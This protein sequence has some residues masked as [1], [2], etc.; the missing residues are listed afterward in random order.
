MLHLSSPRGHALELLLKK[1]ITHLS[2]GIR[3]QISPWRRYRFF[4][5]SSS[6]NELLHLIPPLVYLRA[7]RYSVIVFFYVFKKFIHPYLFIAR[8]TGLTTPTIRKQISPCERYRFNFDVI[9]HFEFLSARAPPSPPPPLSPCTL[10]LTLI[11]ASRLTHLP[12][13]F[14]LFSSR[15]SSSSPPFPT[16][17]HFPGWLFFLWL[18]FVFVYPTKRE[19]RGGG[20]R[21][22][23]IAVGE[24]FGAVFLYPSLLFSPSS[25]FPLITLFLSVLRI[26]FDLL[27][28]HLRRLRISDKNSVEER[29]PFGEQMMIYPFRV[30]Y[31]C[32]VRL[33][34]LLFWPLS[35]TVSRQLM[36][37]A[38]F[39]LIK[40]NIYFLVNTDPKNRKVI[41]KT[42]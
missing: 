42:H 2:L 32:R 41:L 30:D 40:Y 39:I 26:S 23:L 7:H 36:I 5:S 24:G 6:S 16:I 20:V 22:L 38:K 27:P 9:S 19:G 37:I 28:L 4:P 33:S 11:C 3:K 8:I 25:F 12:V 17:L 35:R 13:L 18:P 29:T 21:G 15:L 10:P 31:F 34:L 14:I 1:S